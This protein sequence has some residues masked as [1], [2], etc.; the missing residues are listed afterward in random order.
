MGICWLCLKNG[1]VTLQRFL[2]LEGG[3]KGF[4]LIFMKG[5]QVSKICVWQPLEDMITYNQK[6]I[7]GVHRGRESLISRLQAMDCHKEHAEAIR[8]EVVML[9]GRMMRSKGYV[10]YVK[11]N[12]AIVYCIIGYFQFCTTTIILSRNNLNQLKRD[13]YQLGEKDAFSF[14]IASELIK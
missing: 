6:P 2:W 12:T 1:A 5:S 10:E 3:L 13:D 8:R 14:Q 11:K 7:C 4:V 9:T